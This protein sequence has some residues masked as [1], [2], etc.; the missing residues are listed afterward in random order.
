MRPFLRSIASI[1]LLCGPSSIAFGQ[2]VILQAGGPVNRSMGG[3]SVA[4]PIDAIGAIYWN[5]ASISGMAKSET[6]VAL[7]FLFPNHTIESTVGGASGISKSDSGAFPIPNVG[8][9]HKTSN[10]RL[11]F[12]AGVNAVAG[13]GTNVA[14]STTNPILTP[15]PGGLGQISS[16]ALYLQIAPVLSYAVTEK[17]A[18]AAGPTI[19]TGRVS[20]EPFVLDSANANGTYSTGNASRYHWG[21]GFQVGA[22]YVHNDAVR[23]GASFKSPVWMEEFTFNGLDENGLPRRLLADLD[24]P[25]IISVGGSYLFDEK[26]LGALDV[27]FF[28]YANTDGLGDPPVFDATGALGG[29]GYS[30][31][32]SVSA[33]LQREVTDMLTIRGGYTYNQ[34]P[35]SNAEAFYNIASPVVY[36]HMFSTGA[37]VNF[38]PEFA[39]NLAYSYYL[40]NDRSGPVVLPG[41]GEVPGSNLTNTLDAHLFSFGFTMR[42]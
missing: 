32:M 42:N 27:R 13:F 8:V 2:G 3:A 6:A 17:L 38:T 40:E 25:M 24:L 31:V 12:G 36:E 19:T 41:V 1:V 9:V 21:S 34:N 35:I 16:S 18:L 4:A 7:D 23:L 20:I 11:T 22:F 26:T 28:D 30:S 33:G 37:T 10:E 14:A 15:P 39:A 5:P 29:L